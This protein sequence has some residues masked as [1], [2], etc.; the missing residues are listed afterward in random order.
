L[1]GLVTFADSANLTTSPQPI[2][3]HIVPAI[4]YASF[5]SGT[6]WYNLTLEVGTYQLKLAATLVPL[7]PLVPELV[8]EGCAVLDPQHRRRQGSRQGG[9]FRLRL[10][11]GHQQRGT[12]AVAEG[13]AGQGTPGVPGRGGFGG[14]GS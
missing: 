5:M 2:H 7:G 10:G 3:I 14:R 12:G 1:A 9:V 8:P 4:F 11:R 6:I 13:G